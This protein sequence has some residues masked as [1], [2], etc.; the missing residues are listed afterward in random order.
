MMARECGRGRAARDSQRSCWEAGGKL[1]GD[2]CHV[3]GRARSICSIKQTLSFLCLPPPAPACPRL[4]LP[5]TF[6][7]PPVLALWHTLRLLP[8][9]SDQP[10]ALWQCA[11]KEVSRKWTLRAAGR[12]VF[13][14]RRSVMDTKRREHGWLASAWFWLYRAMLK[15]S[16]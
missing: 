5:R 9:R 12:L 2:N 13:L 8:L 14:I 4:C 15:A 11:E 1:L 16:T 7:Y 10:L 3:E 6:R